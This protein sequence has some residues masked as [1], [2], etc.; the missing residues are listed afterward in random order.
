LISNSK[1]KEEVKYEGSRKLKST[2]LFKSW[3]SKVLPVLVKILEDNKDEIKGFEFDSD[4]PGCSFAY[5]SGRNINQ[6]NV[7]EDGGYVLKS[8]DGVVGENVGNRRYNS[9]MFLA[10]DMLGSL[11]PMSIFDGI[12]N[13]RRN[14][15][16]RGIYNRTGVDLK[17]LD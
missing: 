15:L 1:M 4:V 14:R 5:T 12:Y 3:K 11:E 10:L 2:K 13:G 7:D 17:K 6:V 9:S 8:R 16:V